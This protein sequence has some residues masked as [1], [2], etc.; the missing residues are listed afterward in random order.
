MALSAADQDILD[1]FERQFSVYKQDPIVLY[2]IGEKTK[3]LIDCLK[4]YNVV[5]LLDKTSAGY[6]LYGVDVIS[7]EEAVHR[8]SV[9]IIVANYSSAE[10]IYKRIMPLEKNAG[11]SIYHMN[12]TKMSDVCGHVATPSEPASLDDMKR[13]IDLHDV[14]SFDI[15]DTLV[16]RKSVFPSDVFF[17][18]QQRVKEQLGLAMDFVSTRIEAE[19]KAL[20]LHGKKTTIHEIYEVMAEQ[21]LCEQ[22]TLAAIRQIEIET[23]ISLAVGR[24]DILAAVS[25]AE[26]QGKEIVM[27]SDMYLPADVMQRLLLKAGLNS[28]HSLIVSCDIGKTKY[29]GDIWDH[30]QNRYAGKRILH[31]GDDEYSD[32]LSPKAKGITSFH[33][34]SAAEALAQSRL[35]N[36][37]AL[38]SM[39]LHNRLMLGAFLSY[40]FNS[41]FALSGPRGRRSITSMYS[42]GY[43][44]YGPLVF[45]YLVW[46]MKTCSELGIDKILFISRDGY[47]LDRL[48]RML[49]EQ[50]AGG[51]YFYA[52]RRALAVASIRTD[53]D[54]RDVFRTFFVSR[55]ITFERFLAAAFGVPAKR[56]D[57]VAGQFICN[58]TSDYLLLHIMNNYREDILANAGSERIEYLKYIEEC[59]IKKT[60]RL[61]I[62][63][64]VSSGVTQH[65]FEKMLPEHD[66]RFLYFLTKTEM[67]DVDLKTGQVHSL[68]GDYLSAYTCQSNSLIRHYL[69]AE[70]VFSSPEEQF[71]KF[72]D[73]TR[74]FS[75]PVDE[76]DFSAM[77]EC[78]SG[79]QGFVKDMLSPGEF[80]SKEVFDNTLVDSLFGI[81]FD[82]SRVHVPD[83]VKNAFRITD[84][85]APDRKVEGLW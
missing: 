3:L 8:A 11:V 55:R 18:V 26:K 81:M 83:S 4:D 32:V 52:S 44:F 75:A 51:F 57:A 16:A 74:N 58:V 13:Q 39:P 31:I 37:A 21:L 2:G 73:G 48:Y 50:K 49:P 22:Q 6:T 35:I 47:I 25:Y 12:G 42:V 43:L 66:M 27:T 30:L 65:F 84:E 68:Y 80:M 19:K 36:S 41:P 46:L 64:F 78:H 76:R 69:T 38:R 70:A 72:Q 59:G 33:V 71:V 45:N 5:G 24:R 28:S 61:G 67:K 63:N 23:E 62:I 10:I 60:D 15:F 20:V 1:T 34:V 29:H 56:H 9:I 54:I 79:I 14:V 7:P 85:F 53:D 77:A 82:A 17:A 40:F